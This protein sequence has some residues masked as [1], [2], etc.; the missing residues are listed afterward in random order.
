M[1]SV[2]G[3]SRRSCKIACDNF[4]SWAIITNFADYYLRTGRKYIIVIV[5]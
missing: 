2:G 1:E 3:V 5:Y 4:P